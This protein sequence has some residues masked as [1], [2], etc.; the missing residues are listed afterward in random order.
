MNREATFKEK[1]PVFLETSS[2]THQEI[3]SEGATPAQKLEVCTLFRLCYEIRQAELQGKT[4]SRYPVYASYV[5][6][7]FHS[8]RHNL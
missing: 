5:C 1:L 6:D 8:Q 4:H 7:R 3:F 2:I